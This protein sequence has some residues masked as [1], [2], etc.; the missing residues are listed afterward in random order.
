MTWSGIILNFFSRTPRGFPTG[1]PG[2][3][4]DRSALFG[5]ETAA[6]LTGGERVLPAEFDAEQVSERDAVL[7]GE[8]VDGAMIVEPW[9]FSLAVSP[10]ILER[11]SQQAQVWHVSWNITGSSRMM[12]AAN[13]RVLAEIRTSS[14]RT[15]RTGR[16]SAPSARSW[17]S[18]PRRW[19][20]PGPRPMP[21][22]WRI[23]ARTGARLDAGWL[24]RRHPLPSSQAGL[25][26]PAARGLLAPRARSRRRCAPRPRAGPARDPAACRRRGGGPRRAGSARDL[27]RP[28]RSQGGR[29]AGEAIEQMD[30][31]HASQKLG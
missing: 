17:N 8:V 10:R 12:H 31:I 3:S 24:G 20:R 7:L 14:N 25:G 2:P 21:P 18:W 30:A 4:S 23:E 9:G 11:L 6:R 29:P 27:R 13:G 5:L 28:A 16:T 26:R 1:W 22:P 15:M 19:R